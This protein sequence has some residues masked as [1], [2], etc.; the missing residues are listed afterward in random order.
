[1]R[2]LELSRSDPAKG[3]R[4]LEAEWQRHK[5]NDHNL[6]GLGFGM[7]R[8]AGDT[9]AIVRWTDSVGCNEHP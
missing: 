9:N 2:A 1:M 4:I 6:P 7:A 3:L 5:V 8:A